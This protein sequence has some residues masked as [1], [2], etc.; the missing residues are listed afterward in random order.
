[1]GQ[2]NASIALLG[3]RCSRQ[4][5]EDVVSPG[6]WELQQHFVTFGAIDYHISRTR[7]DM[8]LSYLAEFL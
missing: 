7:C 3:L 4:P 2:Y 1:M 6:D 5:G 8:P